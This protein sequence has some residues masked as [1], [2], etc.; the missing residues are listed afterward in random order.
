MVKR[1]AEQGKKE[2]LLLTQFWVISPPE[3]HLQDEET[4]GHGDQLSLDLAVA[5]AQK[6]NNQSGKLRK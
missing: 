2:Q 6:M 3:E 5:S 1:T 4:E